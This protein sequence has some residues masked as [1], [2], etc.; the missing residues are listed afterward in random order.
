LLD[1]VVLEERGWM[2]DLIVRYD[3][4]ADVL[5]LKVREGALANEE[6][7]DNDVILGYDNEGKMVSVEIF[8]ASKKGLF[9]ALLEL[10]KFRR[11]KVEH[12]LSKIG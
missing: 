10:A 12:L 2:M 11:D 7:L 9:N 1:N 8:D 6:L 3:P 5:V 4:E